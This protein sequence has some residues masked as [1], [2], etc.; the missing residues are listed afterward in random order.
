MGKS[1]RA[2]WLGALGLLL[3]LGVPAGAWLIGAQVVILALLVL[4]IE[5]LAKPRT[6]G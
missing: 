5:P 3:G 4:T 6:R 2:F 1:D